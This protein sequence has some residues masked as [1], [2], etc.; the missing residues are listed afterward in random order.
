MKK[1]LLRVIANVGYRS[2]LKAAGTASKYGT[3]QPKEPEVLQKLR[4]K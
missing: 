4:K 3:Y 1:E 2:A